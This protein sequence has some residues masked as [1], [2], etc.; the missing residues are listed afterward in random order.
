[1]VYLP[2]RPNAD[3]PQPW[4]LAIAIRTKGSPNALVGAIRREVAAVDATVPVAKLRTMEDIMSSADAR[5]ALATI[6]LGGAAAVALLLGVLGVYGV[7]AF[8][9]SRRV[10]EFG[11][12]LAIGASPGE[13]VRMLLRQGGVMVGAGLAVGIPVAFA[14]SGTM[15]ALLFGVSP[16]DPLTF[17]AATLVLA[18]AGLLA[19]YIPARRAAR[20][21]PTKMLRAD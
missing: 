1:M 14:L 4:Q 6:L 5:M 3:G 13:I 19:V 21:D 15:R 2:L 7:L 20:V 16:G 11:L 10:P 9:V 12:R 17:G 8:V 18:T